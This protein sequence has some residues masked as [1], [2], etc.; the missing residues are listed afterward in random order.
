MIRFRRFVG[1]SADWWLSSTT[2]LR[3]TSGKTNPSAPG[4]RTGGGAYPPNKVKQTISCRP[5]CDATWSGCYLGG[6]FGYGRTTWA[7]TRE[8]TPILTRP[9]AWDVTASARRVQRRVCRSRPRLPTP[10][11][12]DYGHHP[13]LAFSVPVI[14]AQRSADRTIADVPVVV[15][16]PAGL[17]V[18]LEPRTGRSVR[19]TR[20][21]ESSKVAPK[22][23]AVGAVSRFAAAAAQTA[24]TSA[25]RLTACSSSQQTVASHAA[26]PCATMSC[27]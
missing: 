16:E 24:R 26:H 1:G 10:G 3:W 8:H 15:V 20:R 7:F 18:V 9:F 13:Q 22:I 11:I 2:A 4:R 5:S 25:S 12:E 21:A 27:A 17:A 23:P 6:E 14:N 19:P